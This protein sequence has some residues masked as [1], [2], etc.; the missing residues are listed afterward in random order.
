MCVLFVVCALRNLFDCR[1]MEV[2]ATAKEDRQNQSEYSSIRRKNT[3]GDGDNDSP[4]LQPWLP[5]ESEAMVN[6]RCHAPSDVPERC[7]LGSS[8]S[9]GELFVSP[10]CLSK[11][12]VCALF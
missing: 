6:G 7:C 10:E 9:G 5:W 12:T 8:S 3:G 2:A 4:A 1:F 11:G